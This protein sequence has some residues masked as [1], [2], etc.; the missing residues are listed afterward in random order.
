[1]LR[2]LPVLRGQRLPFLPARCP[3][4]QDYFPPK[5]LSAR[6]RVRGHS[7]TACRVTPSTGLIALGDRG[8]H[9]VAIFLPLRQLQKGENGA[10][11]QRARP[12]PPRTQARSASDGARILALWA[13]VRGGKG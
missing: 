10:T 6:E 4:V 8:G 3:I 7:F 1:M 9:E 11:L 5:Y 13:C 2:L 12:L